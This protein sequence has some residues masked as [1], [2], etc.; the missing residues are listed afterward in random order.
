MRLLRSV[1]ALAGL[2]AAGAFKAPDI[3]MEVQGG[4]TRS[5]ERYKT[6]MST[7]QYLAPA[8]AVPG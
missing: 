2:T 8:V 3:Q 4:E 7:C 5:A 1:M 6:L